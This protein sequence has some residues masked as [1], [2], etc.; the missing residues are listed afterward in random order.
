MERD[1][2]MGDVCIEVTN[3][4]SGGVECSFDIIIEP[5]GM[6]DAGECL[7]DRLIVCAYSTTTYVTESFH[8]AVFGEDFVDFQVLV[9][10]S[11]S[12]V[13]GEIL[14]AMDASLGILDDEIVEPDQSFVLS[15]VGS[16]I[17]GVIESDGS[18]LEVVIMDDSDGWLTSCYNLL[19]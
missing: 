13:T 6:I 1:D 14:C 12:V 9:P 19:L 17:L 10:V 2:A 3:V 5:T 8:L 15:I 11:T 7:T 16:S 18:T 4:P